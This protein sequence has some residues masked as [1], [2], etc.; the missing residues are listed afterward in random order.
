MRKLR[1]KQKN[2][3]HSLLSS[4]ANKNLSSD[5]SSAAS[6]LPQ[7]SI[8]TIPPV[9]AWVEIEGP[10]VGGGNFHMNDLSTLDFP[11]DTS[12]PVILCQTWLETGNQESRRGESLLPPILFYYPP[13]MVVG[14]GLRV[15]AFVVTEIGTHAD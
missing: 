15:E 5:I 2:L 13:G 9:V 7:V 14:G 1:R 10:G 6:Y 11:G 12:R 4:L 3:R 8:E